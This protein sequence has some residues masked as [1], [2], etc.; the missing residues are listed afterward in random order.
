MWLMFRG[1][2]IS[3]RGT[4]YP[5]AIKIATGKVSAVTGKSWSVGLGSKPQD[6]VVVPEQPWLDGYCVKKGQIRQFVAMPLGA[7]YTAE[8]QITCGAEFGGLQIEV[9]PMKADVFERKF[10]VRK[11][12]DSRIDD[13]FSVCFCTAPAASPSMGLAPGG[14]M[15]QEIF[16][17]PFEPG[18]WDLDHSSRCFVHLLNS[19]VWR[20]VTGEQP[21]STPVT[22]REYERAELPWF[23]YYNEGTSAVSGSKKLDGLKSVAQMGKSNG[24]QPL[25]ENESVSTGNVVKIRKALKPGQVR[26]GAF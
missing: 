13:E 11:T 26:E 17:D 10:P 21:P 16:D 15:K 22:A 18:D 5:F 4:Q 23:D 7:G 14:R 24:D 3:K 1:N 20:S 8:E 9:F 25:P 19:M 2:H 12:Q 6:Y